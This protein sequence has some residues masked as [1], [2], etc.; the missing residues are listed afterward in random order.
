M[1]EMPV[2]F[3][4]VL[5]VVILLIV[6]VVVLVLGGFPGNLV[7]IVCFSRTR[8]STRTRRRTRRRTRLSLYNY[9]SKHQLHNN[10]GCLPVVKSSTDRKEIPRLVHVPAVQK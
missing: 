10:A 1:P 6:L 3:F 9:L 8:T 5:V 2:S 7:T 4:F